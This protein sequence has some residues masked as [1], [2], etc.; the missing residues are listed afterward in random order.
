MPRLLAEILRLK[1][2]IALLIAGAVYWGVE[3][4]AKTASLLLFFLGLGA[5]LGH[6]LGKEVFRGYHWDVGKKLNEAW[7]APYLSRSILAVG[8]LF[9]RVLIY[10]AV[11][12]AMALLVSSLL[13]GNPFQV[14]DAEGTE[15][16]KKSIP[17]LSI[18]KEEVARIWPDKDPEGIIYL[19]GE[20]PVKRYM[21]LAAQ[22]QMESNWKETAKRVEPN[23]VVSYGLLQVC[24]RTFLEMRKGHKTLADIEPVQLLQ[25][26][27]GIRAGII[28]DQMLFKYA[29][30]K[31]QGPMFQWYY[32]LREYNGGRVLLDKERKRAGSCDPVKV[33]A[34]CRRKIIKLKKGTLD[35]CV[36]NTRY[37]RDIFK[38]AQSYRRYF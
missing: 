10:V 35:L 25:A 11:L 20:V 22:I 17:Y 12:I 28:Y 9:A 37:P 14:D 2:P 1:V 18:L 34:E 32:M 38:S 13:K 27:Y 19:Y 26:R 3:I 31:S 7:K 23:G 33:D 6:W 36:V 24:D 4:S 29:M 15:P 5:I 16:P 21:V 30:C 8:M